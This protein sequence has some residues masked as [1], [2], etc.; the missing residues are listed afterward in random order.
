M[1]HDDGER[2]KSKEMQGT[3]ES[4]K[5]GALPSGRIA[6]TAKFG[7]LVGGQSIRWAGTRAVNVARGDEEAE[8]KME[9]RALK[10]ADELVTQLGQMRGAAMKI[11]QV[12]STIDFDAIP[13]GEREAF[14]EKL[15]A[16]RD[17]APP[18]PF[19][20]LKK[21]I[22]K[23]LGGKLS[24]HFAEFDEQAF[25]AA[26]IGQVHRA[27]T[28][29]GDDVVVKIQYPGV[30]EAV[31]TDMRN[32]NVL[33]PLLK[34]LAPGLD[35]KALLGELRERIAE[36]LD[37]EIEAQNQRRVERT[38]RDHPFIK[39]PKVF[40][41]LSARRV[42]VSEFV[43][44]QGFEDVK[45]LPEAD[46]DRYGEIVFRFFMASLHRE[47]FC[48]GDPHPGNYMRCADGSVCFLDFGL[49]RQVSAE[50]LKAEHRLAAA[51]GSDDADTVKEVLSSLGYLPKP[52]DFDPEL[53]MA[54]M[55]AAGEWAFEPGFRR[56][57]PD[58]V[59]E[60]AEVGSSPRSPFFKQMRQMTLPP[61]ALLVRRMEALIFSVLGELRAGGDWHGLGL[62]FW[63]GME[64]TTELGR[65]DAAWRSQQN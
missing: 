6:R 44:G 28:H 42:L 60:L 57:T 7:K 37:Y 27:L 49:M 10:L 50:T 22:E 52:D 63:G 43:E 9:Q 45:K 53:L 58:Y 41:D 11:G 1:V 36:E 17:S 13:E 62:E 32:M 40:T 38:F 15:A 54:Q 31:E 23:D 34:R 26:S 59:R 18:V 5:G 3:E 8:R 4:S 29:D 2:R 24:D 55:M 61:E 46:R 51:V 16:L 35:G 33:L 48:S 20:K 14:K 64:P 25:A 47:R 30:A 12:L 19:S 21:V 65:L 56:I 39:I